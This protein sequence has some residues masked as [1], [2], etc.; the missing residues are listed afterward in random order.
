MR[1]LLFLLL[2][3]IAV[4][5]FFGVRKLIRLFSGTLS[6]SGSAGASTSISADGAREEEPDDGTGTLIS[7]N[8]DGSIV[9]TD[10]ETF[11]Q[12][13][14]DEAGL[15]TMVDQE[16]SEY[17]S[18]PGKEGNVLKKSLTVKK[19]MAELVLEFKS[20]EDYAAFNDCEF[21]WGKISDVLKS[22]ND[23]SVTVSSVTDGK[24][25]NFDDTIA[26]KGYIVIMNED[27]SLECPSNIRYVS[28]NVN[29]TGK[30]K[31]YVRGSGND[32]VIIY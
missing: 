18:Q 6:G 5:L 26:L 4:A 8:K 12:D 32:A 17:V 25:L 29:L 7:V 27:A 11:D 21:K 19:G 22:R 20:A 10:K 2:F 1:F 13:T 15:E 3:L 9:Q 16:I 23:L 28:R 31:A 24:M 14:Y 30:K